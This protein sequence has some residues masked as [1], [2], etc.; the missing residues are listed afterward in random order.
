MTNELTVPVP[1]KGWLPLVLITFLTVAILIVSVIALISG[2]L[3]IFQNLFYIPIILACVYYVKRGF[4][5]SVLLACSYFV[6]M[7]TF[8][9]D[10]VVI[11]G[12]LIRVLIFILV[13]GVITYL[14]IIRIRAEKSLRES[15]ER[16]SSLF[17]NNYSV[18]LIIDPDTGG[19]RMPTQR[20][21]GIT[22][23]PMTSLPHWGFMTLTGCQKRP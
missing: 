22:D 12:A 4:V 16:Y 23:I 11:E 2:W 8:S 9:N 20:Q 19:S 15:E 18:S 10:P 3:T 6:L 21:P 5:F 14:S 17:D 13:A 1:H 7:L